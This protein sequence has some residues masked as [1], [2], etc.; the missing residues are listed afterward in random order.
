MLAEG[1]GF[2]ENPNLDV[3]EVATSFVVRLD[4]PG[5]SDRSGETRRAAADEQHVHRN[6]FGV[7]RIRENQPLERQ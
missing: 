3:A 1:A 6:C 2:L 7:G 4:E 5:E